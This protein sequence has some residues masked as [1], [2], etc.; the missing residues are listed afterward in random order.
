MRN[1]LRT[2]MADMTLAPGTNLEELIDL[3]MAAQR[4]T[5]ESINMTTVE[6]KKEV[7]FLLKGM[8]SVVDE[9]YHSEPNTPG[10]LKKIEDAVYY[11]LAEEALEEEMFEDLDL[12]DIVLETIAAVEEAAH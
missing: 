1:V 5:L 8:N 11:D 6:G 4:D 12:S 10:L 9:Y 2:T 7:E 3:T